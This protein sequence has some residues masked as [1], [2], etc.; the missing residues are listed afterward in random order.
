MMETGDCEALAE[1]VDPS[2]GIQSLIDGLRLDGVRQF[3][4]VRFHYIE[5]LAL[6]ASAHQGSVK[7]ILDGKLEAALTALRLRFEQARSE[8]QS[9]RGVPEAAAQQ[10]TLG[11]LVRHIAQHSPQKADGRLDAPVAPRVELKSVRYFRNTWSRLSAEKQVTHALDQAPKNAGP[12][13]SHAVVLRSLALMRDISPDYLNR[14]MSYVDTLLCLDQGDK[15]ALP[16][17]KPPRTAKTARK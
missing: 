16:A 2:A 7:R 3:D 1:P 6:R 12:I 4:P 5:A 13:N 8:E 15:G 9:A 11:D 17:A 10:Q 14:F